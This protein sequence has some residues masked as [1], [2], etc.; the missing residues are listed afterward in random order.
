MEDDWKIKIIISNNDIEFQ[1]D[2]T[3]DFNNKKFY[4]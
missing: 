1:T 3:D 2:Y 4:L